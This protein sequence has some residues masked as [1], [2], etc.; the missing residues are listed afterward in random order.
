MT[1]ASALKR[2]FAYG[3]WLTLAVVACGTT[4]RANAGSGIDVEPPNELD[5]TATAPEKKSARHWTLGAGVAARPH[6]QGSDGYQGQFAPLVDVQ[7]GRFFAKS[8]EGIGFNVL[9]TPTFRAGMAVNWMT[10]YDQDEAPAGLN[11]VKDAL[12][13]RLFASVR[14]KGT[15]A[16][17]AG[18]KAVTESERGLLINASLAYPIPLNK[19]LVIVPSLGAS[20]ADDDYMVSYFGVD[21]SEAVTSRFSQY[22]PQ[23]GLKDVSFRLSASYLMTDKISVVAFA[24]VTHLLGDAADSPFVERQTQ[25]LGLIGLTYTF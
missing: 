14:F 9:E 1:I 13:A 3:M 21:A 25:P 15:V 16:T 22:Q 17:L 8:G 19:R 11:E 20:W 5:E 23:S 12:G 7:L 18:T 4:E 10:G 2:P 24:G 6:F